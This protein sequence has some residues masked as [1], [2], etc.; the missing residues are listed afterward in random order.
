MMTKTIF[1]ILLI[2][3]STFGLLLRFIDYDRVP[4]FGE[5]RDEFAYPW[6]GMTLLQTGVPKSWS[7]FSA[8]P[9][10]V[11]YQKWGGPFHIVSPW[12][13]Q[14]PL[15]SLIS[16]AWM[17][18]NGSRDLFDVRLSTLRVLPITLSFFTV[19]LTGLLA[20]ALF[21][22]K[23][24]LLSALLYA[25]V[26][27]IVMANRLSLTENLITPISLL[28]LWL[29]FQDGRKKWTAMKPYLVGLG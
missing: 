16:G 21:G 4:A 22:N 2:F 3:I 29:F 23:A 8:Y 25:T 18:L 27:T 17:M 12:L 24:G 6:A 20:K 9:D 15:Y 13:D 5:T 7:W 1:H 26:P 10:G 11:I 14:Q 28:V 19:I